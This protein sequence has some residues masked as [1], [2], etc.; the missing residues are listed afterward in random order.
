MGRFK[1]SRPKTRRLKA[2]DYFLIIVA[3]LMI[4]DALGP[5]PYGV[6]N[7]W[8]GAEYN[9]DAIRLL[10]AVQL[11]TG[12]FIVGLVVFVRLVRKRR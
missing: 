4:I 5:H 2:I 11:L 7:R 6:R 3:I 9:A 12:L 8:G 10:M 1:P